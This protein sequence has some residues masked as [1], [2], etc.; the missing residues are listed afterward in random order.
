MGAGHRVGDDTRLATQI[1]PAE[2]VLDQADGHA[3]RGHPEGVV[4]TERTSG[5]SGEQR[6][7]QGTDIDPH[8][9]D[10]KTRVPAVVVRRIQRAH[11][12][13][14]VALDAAA[15]Q[16][17][18]RQA[19]ADAHEARQD[20]QREVPDHHQNRAVEQ[21]S[22]GAQH[23]VGDPAPGYGRHVDQAA[24]SAD[25]AGGGGLGQPQS[26]V[27]RGNVYFLLFAEN[28]PIL[29][30]LDVI[31][32]ENVIAIH[33]CGLVRT[34][35]SAVLQFMQVQ[36]GATVETRHEADGQ[37]GFYVVHVDPA[38]ISARPPADDIEP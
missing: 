16:S 32:Q 9:E 31:P 17:D 24:V 27:G 26:R 5:E 38:R 33:A 2:G 21:R 37:A 8:V 23:P 1:A 3:D 15:A 30:L 34:L 20:R 35:A 4:E 12:G 14:R 10:R 29:D 7:E 18:T 19:H 28:R 13:G 36:Y 11:H 22:L 25:Q 6:A